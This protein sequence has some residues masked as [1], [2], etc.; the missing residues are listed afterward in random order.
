[1][2]GPVPSAALCLGL[3]AGV[4]AAQE[5]PPS[6][7]AT[8][9]GSP[10]TQ[11]APDGPPSAPATQAASP[12]TQ[13]GPSG[14]RGAPRD[15]L[16]RAEEAYTA[17]DF[18]RTAELCRQ[19]LAEGGHS[20]ERLAR[21]YELLA[22]ALA[23]DGDEAGARDAYIKFLALRPDSRVD[24][25]LA[26]RL[27]SPFMEARG[28]WAARSDRLAVEARL[29]RG[30]R[31]LRVEVTDPIGMAHE[32][33]VLTRAHGDPRP[34]RE[35]RYAV[36]ASRLVHVHDLPEA[37]RIDYVVQLL[38]A[39]GNRLVELG[40]TDE[41]RTV[42]RPAPAPEAPPRPPEERR[43]GVPR[44]VW[45]VLGGVVGAAALG[46]GLGVGLRTKPVDLRATVTFQ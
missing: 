45:G 37:D 32:V 18:G 1:M 33:R 3:L 28:Y 14:P 7:A 30:Q 9:D 38:D 41:P 25:D 19:A 23:A 17:V 8:Q 20:P 36:Q 4:A 15:A 34:M 11:A 31:G 46:I 44:W 2:R 29:V 42:G 6:A 16:A 27:R 40:T 35:T 43:P 22:V 21:I 5:A 24:M 26:P 10:E 39:H 13:A 12:E